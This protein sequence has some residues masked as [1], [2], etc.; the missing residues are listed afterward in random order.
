MQMRIDNVLSCLRIFKQAYKKE[1]GIVT[2]GDIRNLID[3]IDF[4]ED[5]IRKQKSIPVD[6]EKHI[7]MLGKNKLFYRCHSCKSI[8]EH[9]DNF[10][11][12]CGQK[13][14]G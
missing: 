12:N 10:C 3:N 13:I 11:S 7:T 9:G 6:V 1:Y 14:C 5:C 4:I 8:V 2:I